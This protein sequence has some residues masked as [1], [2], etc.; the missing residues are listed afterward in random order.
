MAGSNSPK[1]QLK[2]IYS[3]IRQDNR[4]EAQQLLKQFLRKFLESRTLRKKLL[5][6]GRGG[7]YEAPSLC[8]RLEG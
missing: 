4:R 1:E 7:K 3:L 5:G 8:D 6:L 2:Y